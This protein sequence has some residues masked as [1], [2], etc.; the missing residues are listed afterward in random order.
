MTADAPA[1]YE[2]LYHLCLGY[3][4]CLG[5]KRTL[6]DQARVVHIHLWLLWT[7]AALRLGVRTDSNRAGTL[8]VEGFLRAEMQRAE[9]TRSAAG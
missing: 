4:S 8:L 6:R 9:H 2:A 7:S 3:F 1:S 5:Y